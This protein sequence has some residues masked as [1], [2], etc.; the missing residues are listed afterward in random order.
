MRSNFKN[1]PPL[2]ESYMSKIG[3][4]MKKG[5]VGNTPEFYEFDKCHILK[6]GE[7]YPPTGSKPS[8]G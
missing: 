8:Q 6:K 5:V 1:I 7:I 3:E 4:N 2:F